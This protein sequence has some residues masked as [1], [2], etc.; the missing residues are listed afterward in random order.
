MFCSVCEPFLIALE[1]HTL[2][3][4]LGLIRRTERILRY[5]A[6]NGMVEEVGEG[7]FAASN[8]TKTLS[9]PGFSAGIRHK[10]VFLAF[11]YRIE[12]KFWFD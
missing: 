7:K 1:I 10:L 12:L 8:I 5:L 6:S 11:P 2:L 3:L 9:A 4:A